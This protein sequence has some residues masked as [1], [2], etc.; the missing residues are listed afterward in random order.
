MIG[1]TI[2][3][4]KI[5]SRIG[6]GGM[7][8]V[9]RALDL[10]LQRDVAI[11]CVRPELADLEEVTKRFRNEARTLAKLSHP[12]IATVYRFFTSDERLFLVMEYIDGIQ[13]S[14]RSREGEQ[15][16]YRDA[17]SMIRDALHGLGY[18]HEQGVV[19]RDIKPGNLML[20]QRGMVKVLDFGIAHLIGGTRMTRAGSMVG[21][22]AYMAPEQILGKQVDQRTDLYSLG[23][24]LYELLSGQ[25][26]YQGDSEFELLRSHLEKTPPHLREITNLEIPLKLQQTVERALGKEKEERFQSAVEF[27]AALADVIESESAKGNE[28]RSKTIVLPAPKQG[29]ADLMRPVATEIKRRLRPQ[30]IATG[31]GVAAL[32]LIGVWAAFSPSDPDPVIQSP[33][34][35]DW[36]NQGQVPGS[37]QIGGQPPTRIGTDNSSLADPTMIGMGQPLG[38][39]ATQPMGPVTLAD[40]TV[41]NP[42]SSSMS[43]P[44]VGDASTLPTQQSMPS[45]NASPQQNTSAPVRAVPPRSQTVR[46]QQ[47]SAQRAPEV[48]RVQPQSPAPSSSAVKINV[49]KVSV[50]EKQGKGR[51]SRDAGYNGAFTVVVPPG[52]DRNITVEE[53]VEVRRDGV[54]VK[55]EVVNTA[56][57]TPGTFKSKQ[58]IPQMKSLDVGTY[59]VQLLLVVNGRT[60]GNHKWRVNVVD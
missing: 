5:L 3:Q 27:D 46:T 8:E 12:N 16:T 17:I 55:R 31:A 58:R 7:G 6:G 47:P 54:M 30:Q 11:K 53:V 49:L 38:Q 40:G 44:M 60:A 1:T 24:V 29:M 9:Y 10:E 32:M 13:F 41:I 35:T 39:P 37:L 45:P 50:H 36:P 33:A 59:D 51:F 14:G 57:R 2:D 4:Y 21:T 15:L 19:H 25:L 26:P 48:Q 52:G 43:A 20:D 18:A 56:Q 23:I 28:S 34:S 22:P 42:G